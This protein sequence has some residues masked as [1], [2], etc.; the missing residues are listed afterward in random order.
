MSLTTTT[1][2]YW[3]SS[4]VA[5]A[6][7]FSLPATR[8][9]RLLERLVEHYGRPNQIRSDNG[10]EFISNTL[11]EW[12]ENRAIAWQWIQPGKP[13]Q[14]AYIERFNG[15]FR[16]EVLNAYRFVN[17]RQAREVA[18]VWQIEYNTQRPHQALGFLTPLEFKHVA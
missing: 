14:N 15:T 13:T 3:A 17:L 12:C 7:D 6:I 2:R 1:D 10:P 9:V 11:S 16:R 5:R 18:D 8:V 4:G